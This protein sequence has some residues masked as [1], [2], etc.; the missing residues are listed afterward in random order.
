MRVLCSEAAVEGGEAG[1]HV[2]Q[3]LGIEEGAQR[4]DFLLPSLQLMQ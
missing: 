3:F 2:G 1:K 4:T